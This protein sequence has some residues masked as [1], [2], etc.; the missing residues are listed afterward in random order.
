M[1]EQTNLEAEKSIILSP[2]AQKYLM[3]GAKWAKFLSIIGFIFIGLFS[4]FSLFAG[5]IFSMA[6]NNIPGGLPFPPAMISIIYLSLA[7]LYFFPVYYLYQFSSKSI[8]SIEQLNGELLDGAL[9]NLKSHYKFMGI[10]TIIVIS[11]YILAFIGMIVAGGMF[12]S[13]MMN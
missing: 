3:T 11:L 7:A 2:T 6:G 10:L 13:S 12:L 9:R 4:L 8:Q 5:A 1:E